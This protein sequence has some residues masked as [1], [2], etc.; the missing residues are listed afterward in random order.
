MKEKT[1]GIAWYKAENFVQLRTMFEDRDRFHATHADWLRAA[2]TSYAKQLYYGLT[3]V[4]VDID[5]VLFAAWC[6]ERD[7]RLN[8]QSRVA[9]V[10]FMANRAA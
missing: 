3:V 10:D 6:A 7:I 8:A 9:Y 1:F 5:P 2:E 4:K